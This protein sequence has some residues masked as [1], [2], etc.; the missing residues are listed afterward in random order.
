M[1]GTEDM[2]AGGTENQ[3]LP[4]MALPDGQMPMGLGTGFV[5]NDPHIAA[6][7]ST[8]F[9]NIQKILDTRHKYIRLSVQRDGDNPK[10]DPSWDIY[11]PPR[12]Q[13]GSGLI[14]LPRP[15]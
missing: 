10:D 9:Q 12:S 11:P 15:Q 4:D 6:E 1:L 3:L 2:G 5:D 13:P 14:Q 8:I 7:L